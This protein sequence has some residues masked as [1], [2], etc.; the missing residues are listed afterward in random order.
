MGKITKLDNSISGE[1]NGA[2]GL[3]PKPSHYRSLIARL[4]SAMNFQFPFSTL[5]R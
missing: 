3:K 2:R 5:N 1:S 4:T